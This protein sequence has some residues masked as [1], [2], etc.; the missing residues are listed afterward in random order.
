MLSGRCRPTVTGSAT[1]SPASSVPLSRRR[2]SSFLPNLKPKSLTTNGRTLALG[3]LQADCRGRPVTAES[4]VGSES[5]RSRSQSRGQ[6][7]SLRGRPSN[8]NLNSAGNGLDTVK[9]GPAGGS[10]CRGW[11]IRSLW[12]RVRHYSLWS[13]PDL[14]CPSSSPCPSS[15]AS[16]SQCVSP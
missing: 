3:D 5:Q 8:W 16:L 10:L 1:S 4:V 13:L 11:V 15:G 14:L 2:P 9:R 6:Q 12:P 7:T